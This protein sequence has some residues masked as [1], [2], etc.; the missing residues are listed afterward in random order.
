MWDRQGGLNPLPDDLKEVSMNHWSKMGISAASVALVVALSACGGS[1]ATDPAAEAAP[2]TQTEP[3]TTSA[4]P[5]DPSTSAVSADATDPDTTALWL[6]N[7]DLG[8]SDWKQQWGLVAWNDEAEIVTNGFWGY[9]ELDLV[10]DPLDPTRTVLRV[11]YDK[12]GVTTESG[13][14]LLFTPPVEL[15]DSKAA[16]LSYDMLFPEDFDF[17]VVGGKLPGLFGFDP[18][19][20]VTLD[21]T[22]CA[23]PFPIDSDGCFSARFGYRT[24]TQLG[25]P[26]GQMFYETIPWMSEIECRDTWLCDLPYGEGMVMLTENPESFQAVKGT[27]VNITQEIRLNDA[28]E[29]NGSMQVWYDDELVYDEQDLTI[30]TSDDVEINGFLFH[31][32]FGQGFDLSQGSPVTQYSYFA[33]VEFGDVPTTDEAEAVLSLSDSAWP[34]IHQSNAG[35]KQSA[36]A[37]PSVDASAEF[38]EGPRPVLTVIGPNYLYYQAAQLPELFAFDPADIASGPVH[39][40]EVDGSFPLTMGGGLVDSEA[41]VWW[42]IDGHV[43]R[44]DETLSTSTSSTELLA[45]D[46]SVVRGI[47]G[48]TLLADGNLLVTSMSNYAWIV[49]TTLEPDG[50]YEVLQQID[51]QMVT[52]D[53][54]PIWADESTFSPRPVTADSQNVFL[55]GGTWLAR[56]AYDPATQTLSTDAAWAFQSLEPGSVLV[57]SN[58]ALV[59]DQVCITARPGPTTLQQVYCLDQELGELNATLTPFP[60]APGV[61]ALHTLGAIEATETLFVLGNDDQGRGGVSAFDLGTGENLWTASLNN[62]SEAFVVSAPDHAVFIAHRH[63]P[64]SPFSIVAIDATSGEVTTV[65]EDENLDRNPTGHLASL[66]P[67]GLYYPVPTGMVRLWN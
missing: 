53:G 10:E 14:G 2:D 51:L 17:G 28:G 40:V 33:N 3:A 57:E 30:V 42:I 7:D 43:V 60:D 5:A 46:G 22:T 4:E 1:G 20:E 64:E 6:G 58:A 50:K 26:E 16:R 8:E 23:G 32:L 67:D 24:L 61:S 38:Y 29:A 13:S 21:A 12:D 34:V 25:Y 39:S 15:A 47:N 35:I 11:R 36:A 52:A 27:W 37:G 49:S 55:S 48:L 66:G 62:V 18:G 54:V 59:G 63:N 31:A 19:S 41:H 65:F 56:L 9:D 44:F 45:P